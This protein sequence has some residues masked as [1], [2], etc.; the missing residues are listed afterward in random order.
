MAIR[1]PLSEPMPGDEGLQDDG[2]H[3]IESANGEPVGLVVY[4]WDSFVSYGYPGG[5]N[6]DL[7]NID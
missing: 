7:I 1:C 4:G 3:T 2:V 6:V 5:A